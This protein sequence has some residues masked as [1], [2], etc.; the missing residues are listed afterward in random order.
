MPRTILTDAR[1][2]ALKPRKTV[3][4]VRDG[5]LRG[6]GVRVSP[7]GAK[8]FFIHC[9]HR[10]ERVWKIVGNA[11]AMSVT[12]ARASAADMLAAV[13]RGEDML[14]APEET[15]FEAVVEAAIR[16]WFD[17]YSRT[18]PGN[19]N[20]VL[21]RLR[22]ILNFAA[23]CGHIERNPADGIAFNRR[24][25]LT[26]FLSREEVA[27]LHSALDRHDRRE[28]GRQQADIIRLLLF[29]GCRKGEIINLRRSEVRDGM[30]ALADAKTGPRSVG[31]NTVYVFD[32]S[33]GELRSVALGERDPAQGYTGPLSDPPGID[34]GDKG[35]GFA[36]GTAVARELVGFMWAIALMEPT[37][38]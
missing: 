35:C 9:Q 30:L 26:R 19:A 13:R 31:G 11:E 16:R 3:R 2:R 36:Y 24:P 20:H 4:E 22:Q 8:R 28:S 32:R 34:S 21:E 38:A 14:H 10:G 18:A 6:F 23:A 7:S 37:E 15:V 12:K 29:T 1:V 33:E 5:K 27:R 17:R 25:K